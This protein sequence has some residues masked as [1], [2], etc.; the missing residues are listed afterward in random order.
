MIGYTKKATLKCWDPGSSHGAKNREEKDIN[1]P[2]PGKAIL[3]YKGFAKQHRLIGLIIIGFYR[4]ALE[5]S[6]A[7]EVKAEF[8]SSIEDDRGYFELLLSWRG[9]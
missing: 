8:K 4:K 3:K 7:K 1:L 2:S 9:K 5:I 6:G